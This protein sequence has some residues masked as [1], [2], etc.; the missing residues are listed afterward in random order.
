MARETKVGLISGLAF[1]ICFAIILANRGSPP[2][3]VEHLS[4]RVDN[5]ADIE[6]AV[7]PA[8]DHRTSR[9]SR[10]PR[11]S[12]PQEG[13]PPVRRPPPPR[14]DSGTVDHAA[15]GVATSGANVV[16]PGKPAS[17]SDHSSQPQ[18]A[19]RAAHDEAST[20]R[21]SGP[22][23]TV[24]VEDRSGVGP[25]RRALTSRGMNTE[26]RRRLL[27]Q[28]LN[29]RRSRTP[30]LE[31]GREPPAVDRGDGEAARPGAPRPLSNPVARPAPPLTQPGRYTIQPGDSLYK[32]A[33]SRYGRG[34]SAVVNAIFEANRSVLSSPDM[35]RVGAV[36]TLPVIDGVG[37]PVGGRGVSGH[38]ATVSAGGAAADGP[39]GSRTFRWYQ[40]RKHDRY[41]GIAR[42]QLGDASRWREIAELNKDKFPDPQRIREGVRIKLPVGQ[43][44]EVGGRH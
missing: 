13:T 43:P 3:L 22:Q 19:E 35:L 32:I 21:R 34:S 17:T 33:A 10:V 14:R 37:S 23:P 5:G 30:A 26:Q 39:T 4:Y 8:A 18:L 31:S 9:P 27:E 20:L 24:P 7:Q 25:T 38:S 44:A 29:G 36:L 11:H 42:E 6:K 40:I 16:L 28:A 12:E 2:P 15:T 41:I 1:I